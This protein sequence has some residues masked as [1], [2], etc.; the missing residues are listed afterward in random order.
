MYVEVLQKSFFFDNGALN[1]L[2]LK[3]RDLIGERIL[4]PYILI[5]LENSV[6]ESKICEMA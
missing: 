6:V 2:F 5:I 1:A 4:Q 3:H